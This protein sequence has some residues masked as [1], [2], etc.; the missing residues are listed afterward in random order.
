MSDEHAGVKPA[1]SSPHRLLKT[2]INISTKWIVVR[3]IAFSYYFLL[4]LVFL[5]AANCGF[6]LR[7]VLPLDSWNC[8]IRLN[9]CHRKYR[10]STASLEL[11]NNCNHIW[12]FVFCSSFFSFFFF[13]YI[14]I[15]EWFFLLL[16]FSFFANQMCVLIALL[17]SLSK[18]FLFIYLLDF[19]P[20]LT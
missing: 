13:L 5:V 9:R 11:V 16:L 14:T 4:P 10:C 12:L 20:R 2:I 1:R 6:T 19:G 17:Y 3:L 8:N 15:C 18:N 7:C